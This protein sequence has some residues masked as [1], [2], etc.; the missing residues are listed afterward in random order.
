MDNIFDSYENWRLDQE[1]GPVPPV[2]EEQP[3]T[4]AQA[5]MVEPYVPKSRAT[6]APELEAKGVIANPLEAA[7]SVLVDAPV[8][9]VKGAAQAFAGLPGDLEM[10]LRGVIN[11]ANSAEAKPKLQRFLEGL[12]TD[13]ILPTTE[14]IKEFLD[15]NSNYFKGLRNMPQQSMGEIIAPGGYVKAG[16]KISKGI[17][18]MTKATK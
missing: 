15:D 5:P 16:K 3:M 8:A 4:V 18:A 9:T 1:F 12:E 11:M 10:I 2:A 7:Q 17:S 6:M 14:K 13:T